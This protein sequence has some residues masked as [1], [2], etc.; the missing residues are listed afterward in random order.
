MKLNE[1]QI[2]AADLLQIKTSDCIQYNGPGL[3]F[4]H[5]STLTC[6]IFITFSAN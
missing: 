1:G 5:L 2:S 6:T 4:L 3:K